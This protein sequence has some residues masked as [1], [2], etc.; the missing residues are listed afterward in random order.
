MCAVEQPKPES[1]AK[2]MAAIPDDGTCRRLVYLS[3]MGVDRTD[4]LPYSM[5]NLFGALDKLR[6][7]EQVTYFLPPT[8]LHSYR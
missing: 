6:A 5:E 3:R 1:V 8:F 2:L 7:A 4:R